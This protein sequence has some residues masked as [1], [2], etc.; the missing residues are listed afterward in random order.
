MLC[1]AYHEEC[2]AEKVDLLLV[3]EDVNG[4]LNTQVRGGDKRA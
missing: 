1:D 2:D 3:H 4:T